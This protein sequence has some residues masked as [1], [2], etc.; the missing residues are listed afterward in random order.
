MSSNIPIIFYQTWGRG[1][2][3]DAEYVYANLIAAHESFPSS[4]IYLIG[5]IPIPLAPWLEVVS[6]GGLLNS[7][8]SFT[9]S[10]IFEHPRSEYWYL[11]SAIGRMYFIKD[12]V[13]SRGFSQFIYIESDC[14]FNGSI[15]D[16]ELLANGSE[17]AYCLSPDQ[18]Q[19]ILGIT[20]CKNVNLYIEMCDYV[21]F[22]LSKSNTG[23]DTEMRWLAMFFLDNKHKITNLSDY[24]HS[25]CCD[26]SYS[27]VPGDNFTSSQRFNRAHKNVNVVDQKFYC[28]EIRLLSLHLQG[29]FKADIF[30]FF[31][32]AG[33]LDFL[34][35][36]E[37]YNFSAK[38][39]QL[40]GNT[41]PP[42]EWLKQIDDNRL[43]YRP[44]YEIAKRPDIFGF[45]LVEFMFTNLSNLI[46][47]GTFIDASYYSHVLGRNRNFELIKELFE[48]VI[49]DQPYSYFHYSTLL[50]NAIN[51]NDS[52]SEIAFADHLYENFKHRSGAFYLSANVYRRHGLPFNQKLQE[53]IHYF[54]FD[55]ELRAALNGKFNY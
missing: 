15:D 5:D 31:S 34:K 37:N 6:P 21:Q 4:K 24:N 17:L 1:S 32:P 42:I 13:L 50:I 52:T 14:L 8:H 2:I 28:D 55:E 46:S 41:L 12:F 48:G 49:Q 35:I 10:Y 11:L 3:N 25:V 44:Y 33:K 30:N 16:L 38:E 53:G 27:I 40:R 54:P 47:P 39:L 26:F 18:S 43:Y 7:Y 23:A 29:S 9:S 36:P 45:S 20:F 51:S 22:M 19:G